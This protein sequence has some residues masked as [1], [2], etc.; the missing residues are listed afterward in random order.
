MNFLIASIRRFALLSG[1]FVL[2]AGTAVLVGWQ[3][4]VERLKSPVAGSVRMAPLTA[5]A[6]VFAGGA[7]WTS[8]LSAS[9][10][11]FGALIG[12]TRFVCLGTLLLISSIKLAAFM[13]GSI[14]PMDGLP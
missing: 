9:G 5:L 4:N 8:S 6:F 2:F 7:L 1:I 10:V 14:S 12:W 11:R 13:S 3:L